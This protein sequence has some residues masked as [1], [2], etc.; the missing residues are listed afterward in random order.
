MPKNLA[1]EKDRNFKQS[2][3]E[4]FFSPKQ[5]PKFAAPPKNKLG[6][7]PEDQLLQVRKHLTPPKEDRK[8]PP[9]ENFSKLPLKKPFPARFF[10][11]RSMGLGSQ[12]QP[13]CWTKVQ[14]KDIAIEWDKRRKESG[15]KRKKEDDDEEDEDS[16]D[17]NRKK[18]KIK[19][20]KTEKNDG[21]K[22]K[23]NLSKFWNLSRC[24]QVGPP[25]EKN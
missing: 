12:Q 20:V 3:L 7:V 5:P 24:E 8:L 14:V 11:P 6:G 16:L 22:V 2:K 25:E 4:T 18:E 1:P 19:R 23:E 17:K 9:P 13:G 10:K 21:D 15:R